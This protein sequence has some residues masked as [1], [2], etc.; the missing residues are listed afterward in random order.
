MAFDHGLERLNGEA[1]PLCQ[2]AGFACGRSFL[3]GNF[4]RGKSRFRSPFEQA[5]RD[6]QDNRT[7]HL[8]QALV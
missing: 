2:K 6:I 4:L 3:R 8:Q 5:L 7:K 1:E